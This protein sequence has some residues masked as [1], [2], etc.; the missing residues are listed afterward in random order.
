MRQ[1]EVDIKTLS[2]YLGIS[3]R[4][5]YQ[6]A[7]N[8]IIKRKSTGKY[9]FFESLTSYFRYLRRLI[10]KY[11]SAY[12]EELRRAGRRV[13]FENLPYWEDMSS[14]APEHHPFT[15]KELLEMFPKDRGNDV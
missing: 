5:C 10:Q 8:N 6:L 2:T 1:I 7:K 14:E 13:M 11:S 3:E 4:R 15:E 12:A 9:L